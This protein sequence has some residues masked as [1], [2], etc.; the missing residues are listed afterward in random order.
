MCKFDDGTEQAAK[1]RDHQGGLGFGWRCTREGLEEKVAGPG[2]DLTD[3]RS[4]DAMAEPGRGP[5][6]AFQTLRISC[7]LQLCLFTSF[8][9]SFFKHAQVFSTL[10]N[11]HLEQ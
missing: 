10:K 5:Q 3:K 6:P 4:G 7:I 8:F 1:N 11:F 9:L 2:Q